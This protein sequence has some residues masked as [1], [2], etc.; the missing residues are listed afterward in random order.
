MRVR[1]PGLKFCSSPPLTEVI[2]KF[3]FTDVPLRNNCRPN[4]AKVN[5]RER[6]RKMATGESNIAKSNYYREVYYQ[7][8]NTNV[9]SAELSVTIF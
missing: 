7:E 2:C 3:I 6:E 4:R 8:Y 1:F 9:D 5:M